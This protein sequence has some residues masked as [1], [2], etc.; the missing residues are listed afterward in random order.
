MLLEANIV[1]NDKSFILGSLTSVKRLSLEISALKLVYLE[2][3]IY[4]ADCWNLLMLMLD[5]SPNL[6]V[7]KLIGKSLDGVPLW[8]WIQPKNIPKC[9][10]LHLETFVWEDYEWREDEKEVTKYILSNASRL[11]KAT[12]LT[13][14]LTSKE[15]VEMVE[16]LETVIKASSS[17]QLVFK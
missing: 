13:K 16:E 6:Q 10:L 17:C 15:R 8:K 14:R 11:D 12:F 3:C 4:R 9:K 2:L 7:L 5:H 1:N